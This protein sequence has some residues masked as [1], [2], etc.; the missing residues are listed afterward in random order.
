MD[1]LNLVYPKAMRVVTRHF[2]EIEE[3]EVDLEVALNCK[4]IAGSMGMHFIWNV[5]HTNNVFL[6]VREFFCFYIFNPRSWR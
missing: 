4:H 6:E 1:I 2:I 5:S 3:F